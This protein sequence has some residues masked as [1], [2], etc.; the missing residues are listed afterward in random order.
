MSSY[1]TSA[2]TLEQ[3]RLDGIVAECQ[4]KLQDAINECKSYSDKMNA[5]RDMRLKVEND[6]L[7]KQKQLEKEINDAEQTERMQRFIME[8]KIHRL[9]E[10]IIIRIN[11]F[12]SV[13]HVE[14]LE[15]KA[16]LQA[17]LNRLYI[18]ENCSAIL[19]EVQKVSDL[20]KVEQGR[21]IKLYE[22]QRQKE[23]GRSFKVNAVFGTGLYDIDFVSLQNLQSVD[24]VD[25][26][27]EPW[28]D[29]QALLCFAMENKDLDYIDELEELNESFMTCPT[30][31]RNYFAMLNKE[32]LQDIVR[33]QIENAKKEERRVE[34]IRKL[35][36]KYLSLCSLL[37]IEPLE[38][39]LT[40]VNHPERY[41]EL[42]NVCNNLWS[43]YN[44]RMQQEYIE[45]AFIK[46]F[47]KY[48][49]D[50]SNSL[51][52]VEIAETEIQFQISDNTE[53]HITHSDSG[54]VAFQFGVVSESSE[55]SIDE[56]YTAVENAQ[57]VCGCISNVLKELETEYG[58]Y[59][60]EVL[61]EE[62][63]TENIHI[64]NNEKFSLFNEKAKLRYL[65]EN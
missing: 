16:K 7:E 65:D 29:F 12:E 54:R 4:L 3:N 60:N 38:E 50:Y 28:T 57:K 36:D 62:P 35:L 63:S 48:N 49:I 24:N 32:R 20:E 42:S 47:E 9:A 11:T 52:R 43:V 2:F 22:Q 61:R 56:K 53:L 59:F 51:H 64:V 21:V 8:N 31:K 5:V 17:L 23:I 19:K 34:E 33:G 1:I 41:D 30:G 40:F 15:A 46:V 37:E 58:I 55:L 25:N 45:N 39:Y 18:G 6:Y 27:T 10:D 44:K 26:P 13:Y 14:R